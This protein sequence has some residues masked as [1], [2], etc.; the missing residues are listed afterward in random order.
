MMK[1]DG[2]LIRTYLLK[3]HRANSG[4]LFKKG[5]EVEFDPDYFKDHKG[6]IKYRVVL[7]KDIIIPLPQQ[8]IHIEKVRCFLCNKKIPKHDA[9]HI[10]KELYRCITHRANTIMRGPKKAM[11]DCHGQK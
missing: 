5:T 9:I 8:Y 2:T 10:G 6:T 3:S 7:D 4:R 11:E 1:Q